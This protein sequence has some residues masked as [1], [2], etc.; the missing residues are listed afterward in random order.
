MPIFMVTSPDGRKFKVNGPDGS[1][2]EDAVKYAQGLHS[3]TPPDTQPVA[4]AQPESSWASVPKFFGRGEANNLGLPIDL[5]NS[6]INGP[7]LEYTKSPDLPADAGMFARGARA[8]NQAIPQIN[9]MG[10]VGAGLRAVGIQPTDTP[11]LGGNN[12]ASMIKNAGGSVAGPNEVPVGLPAQVAE[13]VGNAVGGML[14]MG[15]AMKGLSMMDGIAGAIGKSALE[16]A[17]VHPIATISGDIASG[18]YSGLGGAI[19]ENANPDSPVAKS[20]GQ[21]VGGMGSMISPTQ[22]GLRAMRMGVGGFQKGVLPFTEAGATERAAARVQGLVPDA[23]A[24]AAALDEPTISNL[25]PAQRIGDPRLLALQNTVAKESAPVEGALNDRNAA[26]MQNLSD[27]LL[28][29]KGEGNINDTKT[30]L[31][32]RQEKFSSLLDTRLQSAKD[33]TDQAVSQLTPEMRGS[34]ASVIA[35][36]QLDSALSDARSREKE[37]WGQIP[38]NILVDKTNT[39]KTYDDLVKN[40]PRAQQEDIP[41]TLM[42]KVLS[43][44]DESNIRVVGADGRPLLGDKVPTTE[45]VTEL[46]G[47]RSK[48]LEGSRQ[49][50]ADG[51]YNSAR[52]HDELADSV[53][54]DIGAAP[55]RIQGETGQKIRDALDFSRTLND[56]FTRGEVGRILGTSRNGGAKVAPELTLNSVLGSG[57]VKGDVGL[58]NMLDAADS[59]ELRGG[60]EN[61][62]KDQLSSSVMKNGV[63]NSSAAKKFINDNVDILD[64]FPDLKQSIA[65][66]A[67]STDTLAAKS[68]RTQQLQKMM[69]NDSKNQVSKFI[70]APIDKEF[71]VITASR[72]PAGF[73]KDLMNRVSKDPTGAA[74]K[75]LKA[76]A[77]D[78][79]M[80]KSMKNGDLHGETLLANLN[81][82]PKMAASIEQILTP[83]E[84]QR[85]RRI[86]GEMKS[87]QTNTSRDI[88]GVIN[89]IPSKLIEF[90]LRMASASAGAEASK[91]FFGGKGELVASGMFSQAAKQ[92][93]GN[94]TKDKAHNLLVQAVQDPQLM[95]ALLTHTITKAGQKA[96]SQKLEAWLLGPGATLLHEDDKKNNSQK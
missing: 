89:D 76:S 51:N 15:G 60:V 2:Q 29:I 55:D 13:G 82:N 47:L 68:T 90:P 20:I 24:A 41:K 43:Q 19:A 31:N 86:G 91:K 35:R 52:I 18:G 48:L 34:Q 12:I 78:Y 83:D 30:A 7:A 96:A 46:Q 14:P 23:A 11:F 26:N 62:L 39:V 17:A 73:T 80:N 61:Y 93:A 59:P 75:G 58:Q 27:E 54:N 56:K 72:D 67:Q 22:L 1:T 74:A 88:G 85:L 70:N 92:Y 9:P 50:R 66:A 6:A 65:N 25:T 64:K 3:T 32:A 45:R 37:L 10:V 44:P 94:L 16:S 95:K 69:V 42:A 8:I 33:N 28:K 71:D 36:E 81:N 40:T 79:V 21:L 5:V 53:L 4:N 87:I 38:D 63:L 57:K 77:V 84:M 49:A